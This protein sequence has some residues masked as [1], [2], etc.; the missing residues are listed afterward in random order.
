[1]LAAALPGAVV[2]ERAVAAPFDQVWRVVVDLETMAPRYETNVTAIEVVERSHKRVRIVA[3]LRGGHV[4]E[5]DVRIVPGWCLMQ[6]QTVI[7]AFGARP[8]GSHTV[9]AHLEYMRN[10]E[11]AP[12]LE[13]PHQAYE[14]LLRELEAIENLAVARS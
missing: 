6:S 4:E 11:S 12:N 14:T 2:A 1:M 9:L 3:T 5:M 10:S 8:A 13:P 7:I